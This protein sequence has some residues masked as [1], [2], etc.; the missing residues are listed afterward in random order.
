MEKGASDTSQV[1]IIVTLIVIVTVIVAMVAIINFIV[2][3]VV[4]INTASIKESVKQAGEEESSE[5]EAAG[6]LSKVIFISIAF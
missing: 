2:T 4:I 1:I 3:M 6:E 5:D